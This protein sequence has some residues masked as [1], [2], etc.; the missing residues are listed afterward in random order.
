MTAPIRLESTMISSTGIV[1]TESREAPF[2]VAADI[3]S[4]HRLVKVRSQDWGYMCCRSYSLLMLY[5]ATKS[6]LSGFHRPRTGGPASS[7]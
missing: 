2:A 5:G 1:S 3:K 6:V 7:V 4:A